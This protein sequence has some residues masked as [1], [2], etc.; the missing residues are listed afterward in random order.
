M[1]WGAC[2]VASQDLHTCRA[3]SQSRRCV[4][5]GEAG[6]L[7]LAETGPGQGTMSSFSH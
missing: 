1:A 7:E 5:W 4:C 2:E 3:T 6:E